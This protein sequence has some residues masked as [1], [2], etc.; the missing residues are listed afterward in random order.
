MCWRKTQV[1]Y[2]KNAKIFG[3]QTSK[4][5][6]VLIGSSSI[7]SRKKCVTVRYN[8]IQV[9]GLNN[10]FLNLGKVSDRAGKK[11]ATN[12]SR[13]PGRA[14]EITSNIVTMSQLK[15]LKQLYQHYPKCSNFITPEKGFTLGNLYKVC[16]IN[17]PQMWQ[18]ISERTIKKDDIEHR[19][20]RKLNDVNSFIN[21]ISNIKE[22]ITYFK[23]KNHKSK[24]DIKSIKLWTQL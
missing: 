17:G 23:D 3:V 19:L 24:R 2:S 5:S 20:E 14:L 8:T 10:F 12:V 1:C 7:C 11:L 16:Y 6:K 15:T 13:K 4:G 21:H 18:I 22:M 9:D